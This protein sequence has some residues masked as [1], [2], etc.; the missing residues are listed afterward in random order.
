MLVDDTSLES[1]MA[2]ES[3]DQ[4][5]EK[6]EMVYNTLLTYKGKNDHGASIYVENRGGY[7]VKIEGSDAAEWICEAESKH[8]RETERT[9]ERTQKYGGETV[10]VAAP[11]IHYIHYMYRINGRPP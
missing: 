8:A 10:K 1:S 11:P 6:I 3:L 7:L 9:Q 4:R 5:G 2:T